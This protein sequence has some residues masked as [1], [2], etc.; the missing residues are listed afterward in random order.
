MISNNV[1]NNESG[2]KI[3]GGHVDKIEFITNLFLNSDTA[4]MREA[5]DWKERLIAALQRVPSKADAL[6][7]VIEFLI[8]TLQPSKI[9]MLK[10]K[11]IDEAIPDRYF[12]LLIVMPSA[13][14]AFTELEPVLDIAYLQNKNVCCSLHN[15][16]SVIEGLKKGHAFYVLN[17]TPENIVYDNSAVNYPVITS[18]QDKLMRRT[19]REVFVKRFTKAKGF[20]VCSE[21]EFSNGNNELALFMLHQAVELTCHSIIV[22]LSGYDKKMHEIKVFK[23][24]IRR[25]APQLLPIF[26]EDNE[27]EKEL[28]FV[29]EKGYI[30]ARYNTDFKVESTVLTLLFKKV[31]LFQ[32]TAFKV[33]NMICKTES[34]E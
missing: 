28:L 18:E 8:A 6:K 34:G 11:A 19:A 30:E 29:L 33:V 16:G 31:K 10:Y 32:E 3:N 4:E 22:S 27:Q 9:Y 23:K 26:N 20:Y 21:T 15:E 12:D 5:N 13:S 25:S 24:H 7:P 1:N 14:P 17:F 2:I